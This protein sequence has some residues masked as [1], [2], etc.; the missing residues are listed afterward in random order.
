[1]G[2]QCGTVIEPGKLRLRNH[3]REI[4]REKI[5]TSKGKIEKSSPYISSTTKQFNLFDRANSIKWSAFGPNK[6]M[7]C[8]QIQDSFLESIMC[9]LE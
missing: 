3:S 2:Q 9:V 4:E 5:Q 8:F 6:H 1:M 7:L